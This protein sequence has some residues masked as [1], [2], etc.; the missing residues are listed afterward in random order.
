MWKHAMTLM[1]IVV[2]VALLFP[3]G[4]EKA[5]VT[6]PEEITPAAEMRMKQ[7]TLNSDMALTDE[8]CRTQC[9]M[10]LRRIA[11]GAKARSGAD[12]RSM[13]QTLRK[14]HPHMELLLVTRRGEGMDRVA[15]AAGSL[16]P[17]VRTAAAAH[18]AKAKIAVDSGRSYQSPPVKADGGTYLIVGEPEAGGSAG[19]IGVVRQHILQQVADHQKKNLRIETYPSD[20]HYKIESVDARTLQDVKV[21]HPEDNEGTSHYHKNQVVV[22]F[23]QVPSATDFEKMKQE[24]GGGTVQKLG[25]TY[26]FESS[27]MEAKQ[28]M[29]YF[30]KWNI[31][32]SE[33]H[34]LYLTN[35]DAAVE[36]A[37]DPTA[38]LTP[39]DS[40]YRR[41][42]YNLPEIATE[43]GWNVSK[44]SSDV[45]VAVVDT[46]VDLDHP[47][48]K[49]QLVSGINI[50]DPN[51]KPYDDVGHGTHVA[52][53]IGALTNNNLGVAGMSWYNRIMPIKVLDQTG[54]GSTYAVAQGIIWATDHGAKV[55]N[56][57][58]GNY[59][60]AEFL[61]D[62]IRYA[63]DRDV[64]LVAASGNDNTERPGFPAAY[65]EVLG[66]AAVDANK[67][68]AT[69]SNYGD[70]ISVTAPGVSIAST[71]P[72]NQYAAL[73]GT[74]MASPHAAA[75]AGL[76]RSVNPALKN[77][78]VMDI[79]KSTSGDL[80]TPGHDRYYGHGLIDVAA[81]LRA[82]AAAGAGTGGDAAGGAGTAAGTETAGGGTAAESATPAADA[83]M[84]QEEWEEWVRQM[85]Q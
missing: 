80:G 71:Y 32:Y 53:V 50:V 6:P 38:V 31:A 75:L 49:D 25:Y 20:G 62:A 10:E 59:A 4:E 83:G 61:H 67:A 27:K 51:S 30:K 7:A 3:R 28:L 15:A 76:I 43:V 72:Q 84:T 17:D 52:G 40:L 68:K 70:Y 69:F 21:D 82:A 74:S 9:S 26:V 19:V 54:A 22:R 44:G 46:G 41:Y 23:K 85:F 65:P 48:L 29:D 81:A 66:V 14:E 47:D 39:N 34:F 24:I 12:N 64:V 58:L 13:L 18:V 36:P 56:M 2:G 45:I 60:D 73:S 33:P 57:S 16:K 77:T 1:L 5:K 63:F 37:A 11:Q 79:M 8:L 55:I 35:Q 42:Q 78:E